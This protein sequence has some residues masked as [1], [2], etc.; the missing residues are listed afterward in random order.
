LR[1]RCSLG[2]WDPLPSEEKTREKVPMFETFVDLPIFH[3]KLELTC[4][5]VGADF[6]RVCIYL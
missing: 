2:G 3:V 4:K 6:Y 5:V 1:Y